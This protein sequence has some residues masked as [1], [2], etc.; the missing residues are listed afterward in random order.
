M[1]KFLMKFQ[2]GE[3]GKC[4]AHPGTDDSIVFKFFCKKTPT[5]LEI[6]KRK[7]WC[8]RLFWEA[9]MLLR[10]LLTLWIALIWGT[11]LLLA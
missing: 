2:G 3:G 1:L 8:L 10:P 7:K 4:H 11:T 5:G 9:P 6:A